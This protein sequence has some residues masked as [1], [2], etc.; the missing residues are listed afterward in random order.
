VTHIALEPGNITY[1]IT[2]SDKTSG[3][4]TVTG[5]MPE[6]EYSAILYNNEKKRGTAMFTTGIDIGT[7]TLVTASDDLFQMIADASP[8]DVLVLD[9][10]DYTGQPG[11]VVLDKSLTL[12]GLRNFDKPLLN[13]NF[14]L[15]SGAAS[16]YLIDLDL[17]GDGEGSS[18][19]QDVARY[20]G[21]GAYDTLMVS[22]CN[23]HD[24]SRSFI[25]GNETDAIVQNVIV[26]NCV[27]TNVY[28]SGGDFI[29]F[30]NSDVL[31]VNVNT[32]TFNNCAPDRD[33]FRL[34]DAGTSTQQ[35]LVCNV[36]L[37]QC[38]LYACSN[39]SSRR[40]LYVRFQ[41]N[42]IVVTNTIITDTEG[43]YSNQ[44]RTDQMPEFDNNNY[45]NAPRFYDTAEVIHDASGDYFT[46]DPG[47]VDPTTGDFTVTNQELLDN[48]VGDPRWR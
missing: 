8:G 5:L 16:V 29:D 47:Y 32:S 2:A 13:I 31:N 12:R 17:Q 46:V 19:L 27:V 7:G 9:S 28:T 33:F 25:A 45:F 40:I 22:G 11:T 3:I 14:E 35:G 41:A 30:R 18:T 26:E 34:D 24:Y 42:E 23:I 1:D 39:S 36:L 44:S 20:T 38:T 43:F 6:T 48:A 10:G 15:V 4:A 21:A 37:D